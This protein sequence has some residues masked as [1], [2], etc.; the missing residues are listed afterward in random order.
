MGARRRL[1]VVLN[2]KNRVFPVPDA[3]HSPVVEVKMG[4]LKRLRTGHS[5]R[6][7][8]HGKTVILRRDK[9]LSR[10]EIA[11]RMVPAAMSVR[12]FRRLA[13]QGQAE[14]LMPEADPED[15]E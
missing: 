9:Y 14:E 10:I 12:E 15:R 4:D 6:L 5:T 2:G 3:L 13:T 7:P 8:F 11:Y 1:R